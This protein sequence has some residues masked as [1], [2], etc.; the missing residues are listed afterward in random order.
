MKNLNIYG[1]GFNDFDGSEC[2]QIHIK[3][4]KAKNKYFNN[5]WKS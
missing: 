4:D 1:Y 5:T 3:K 2:D